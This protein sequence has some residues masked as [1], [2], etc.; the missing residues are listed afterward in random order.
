MEIPSMLEP[1]R[2]QTLNQKQENTNGKYIL[3]WMQASV[4]TR[5]NHAL[6][7]ALQL[8]NQ[9]KLPVVVFF[10]LINNYPEANARH[11]HFLLEGL[12]D[13][14]KTLQEKH[15][16]F[17]VGIKKNEKH[18]SLEKLARDARLVIT[19]RGYTRFQ[20]QWRE[21][22]ASSIS[23]S[24]VQVE[25]DVVV[26][27]ETASPKE[28]YSAYTLRK[29]ITPQIPVFLK[30][31]TLP[32]PKYPSLHFSF[33]SLDLSQ[34]ISS[35]IQK[36][37]IDHTIKSS[38]FFHAGEQEAQKTLKLFIRE[39]LSHY[40]EHRNDPS[41]DG[42]SNLSPYLHFG[43][44]SPIDIIL[45]TKDTLSSQEAKD[46]LQEELIVRRELAMNFVFYNESYD[47]FD[48]LPFWAKNTLEKHKHDKREYLYTREQLETART[49]DPYWNASQEEML[50]TGKMHGYMRMYWGKKILEWSKTPQEAF[51]T[52]LYLNNKYEL[53]G[54][55]PN[56]FAGVAW[57]FGKHDRP[58][59]EREIF[60]MVRY[61]NA[62]G[63]E[64][65][66]PIQKYV[67]TIR[68]LPET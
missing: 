27:V 66:F 55:D 13:V 11:Y 37:K 67:A 12:Q 59:T 58:W 16:A 42:L 48:C 47:S 36:L 19:D 9:Y 53:D 20:R 26:P 45:Q 39:K 34:D 57:C 6:N 68:S 17:V 41:L 56:G 51:E 63:L 21:Q 23:Y 43:H 64:R 38:S 60:G 50:L 10:Q 7:Y 40:H 4:R 49:H 15:I 18:I 2:I 62:K 3:Y 25:S 5:Y 44:I 8:G 29:K 31:L 1:S 30:P 35:L 22:L 33:P 61:M 65:K 28:E 24:L 32:T 14:Q 54:R 46:T 52:A